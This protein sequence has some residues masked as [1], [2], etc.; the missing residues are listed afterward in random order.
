MGAHLLRVTGI[1]FEKRNVPFRLGMSSFY[2]SI[3]IYKFSK[4]FLYWGL[5][6][7]FPFPV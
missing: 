7:G 6:R 2:L 3:G 4:K 1:P 5:E